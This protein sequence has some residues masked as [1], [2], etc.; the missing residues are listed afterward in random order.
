[1]A[2]LSNRNIILIV[3]VVV[4]LAAAIYLFVNNRNNQP[5]TE[6]AAAPEIAAFVPYTDA[7]NGLSLEMPN[8]WIARQTL[9]GV[10]IGT[11]ERVLGIESFAELEQEG[12]LVIIPG[13]LDVL[14]FQ[15]GEAF[16][17]EDPVALLTLYVDLLRREGQE[18]LG[19]TPPE[20]FTADGQEGAKTVLQSR[21][22]DITLEI[23]MAAI[24]NEEAR[25]VA[26]VSTAA[27]TDAAAALRP[28]FEAIIDTIHVEPPSP[29][30]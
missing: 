19:V 2:K 7:E 11:S 9:P 10:T 8:N 4:L 29:E 30:Q 21:Q 14:A 28:T 12:V 5:E 3:L 23:I 18:Y 6:D 25:Y 15:T 13:E 1:M 27:Q 20:R 26:F 24:V 17:S 22:D 16:T